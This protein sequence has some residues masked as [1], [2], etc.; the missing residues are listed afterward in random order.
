[1]PICPQCGA[2]YDEWDRICSECHVGLVDEPPPAPPKSAPQPGDV[3]YFAVDW[4]LL[5][6]AP[7]QIEAHFIRGI[8]ESAGIPVRLAGE[9]IAHIYGV[10]TGHLAQTRLFVPVRLLQEARHVLHTSQ[11]DEP[12]P[13]EDEPSP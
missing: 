6:T 8:L 3:E 11:Q 12:I 5:C 10:T 2:T 9:A 4:A 7:N 13:S 1:M